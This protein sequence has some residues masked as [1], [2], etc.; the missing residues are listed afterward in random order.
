MLITHCLGKQK[1]KDWI[2]FKNQKQSSKEE[3]MKRRKGT[4]DILFQI[5][6]KKSSKPFLVSNSI[7]FSILV[8]FELFKNLW[9]HQLGIYK[10]YCYSKCN[11]KIMKEFNFNIWNCDILFQMFLKKNYKPSLVWNPK[12]LSCKIY[13]ELSKK[14]WVHQLRIYKTSLYSKWNKTMTK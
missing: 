12:Y 8:C 14:L 3:N 13:F 9:V 5:Y 2:F 11:K 10:T 4:S 6:K 7:S 1:L